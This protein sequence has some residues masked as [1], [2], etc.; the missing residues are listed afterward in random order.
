M[1]CRNHS[2]S[3]GWFTTLF[4]PTDPVFGY[5]LDNLMSRLK[6][7]QCRRNVHPPHRAQIF[8]SM[9]EAAAVIGASSGG[10]KCLAPRSLKAYRLPDAPC[11][12]YLPTFTPKIANVGKYSIHGASGSGK[13]TKNYGK[14]PSVIGKSTINGP[15]SIGSQPVDFKEKWYVWKCCVPHCAH[16]C[17]FHQIFSTKWLWLEVSKH[18]NF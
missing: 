5:F 10:H 3:T 2:Q 1:V 14:S 7:T 16:C 4:Y 13:H 11:M 9:C 17:V 8:D 15:I 18:T 12:E 6:G